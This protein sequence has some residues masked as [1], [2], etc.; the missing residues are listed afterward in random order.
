MPSLLRRRPEERPEIRFS[1]VR[2]S[3]TFDGSKRITSNLAC[4]NILFKHSSSLKMGNVGPLLFYYIR[5]H[6]WVNKEVSWIMEIKVNVCQTF[7]LQKNVW[8]YKNDQRPHIY[9]GWN[10][11]LDWHNWRKYCHN[12]NVKAIG[13][14][15]RELEW[16]LIRQ[17]DITIFFQGV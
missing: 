14:Y 12:P 15:L 6:R 8:K 16:A 9:F 10:S 1:H 2:R 17:T 13:H 4:C 5:V 11:G 3:D 7:S